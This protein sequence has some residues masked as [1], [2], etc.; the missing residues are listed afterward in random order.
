[1]G[2]GT[3]RDMAYVWS[4]P[5][6]CAGLRWQSAAA[7]AHRICQV[8]RRV[9]AHRQA[10]RRVGVRAW[11]RV[12]YEHG[13]DSTQRGLFWLPDA[14]SVVPSPTVSVSAASAVS[15][16]AGTVSPSPPWT[17]GATAAATAAASAKARVAVRPVQRDPLERELNAVARLRALVF[18][19]CYAEGAVHSP[20]RLRDILYTLQSRLRND[21]LRHHT[22][23]AVNAAGRSSDALPKAPSEEVVASVDFTVQDFRVEWNAPLMLG[24][25]AWRVPWPVSLT[26]ARPPPTS[27]TLLGMSTATRGWPVLSVYISGLSVAPTHRRRGHARHLLAHT[28]QWTRARDIPFL[29]LHVERHNQ[30]A[31]QL[32]ESCNFYEQRDPHV[33]ELW[34]RKTGETR[35]MLMFKRLR[36]DGHGGEMERVRRADHAS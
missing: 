32:Y 25:D 9:Q 24:P 12:R 13:E 8:G 18:P 29:T 21:P 3:A 35:H 2:Q 16:A 4:A 23:V 30:A 31:I 1:M 20:R 19:E 36:D 34:R 10:P 33:L 17:D 22:L 5:V 6:R 26:T 27:A 7:A 28:E 14:P 15:A 11:S